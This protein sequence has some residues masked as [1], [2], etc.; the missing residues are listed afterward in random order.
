M[1]PIPQHELSRRG[2]ASAAAMLSAFHTV[3]GLFAEELDLPLTPGAT[4]GPYYPDQFPLDTDN[5]LIVIND[6]AV[7]SLG[8]VAYLSG[9][10]TT[11][12]GEPIRNATVEIWQVDAKGV[13]IHTQA[14]DQELG[15]VNFQGFGRF[16]TGSTGEYG[17]RTIVPVPY[18]SGSR[19]APH[20]HCAVNLNGRRVLTTQLFIKDHPSN[21]ADS[22][23]R[24]TGTGQDISSLFVEFVPLPE[25]V[26]GEVEAKFD[27]V[28]D[29]T[30]DASTQGD[31]SRGGVGRGRG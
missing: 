9:R 24:N 7:P 12:S 23:I 10:V 11:T 14:P 4:E 29:P 21:A 30:A 19:T 26:I 15:D 22:V 18:I 25:S 13:Y 27:M 5:D 8:Q 31:F 6:S 1:K 28:V 17:F 2:F 20:I 3:P 16:L